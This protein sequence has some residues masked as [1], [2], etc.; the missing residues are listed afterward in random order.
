M[1]FRSR[2]QRTL[3]WN[4]QFFV[5]VVSII[6]NLSSS[7]KYLSLT[8]FSVY[9]WV[10]VI[11]SRIWFLRILFCHTQNLPSSKVCNVFW[12]SPL[13][14]SAHL[15]IGYRIFHSLLNVLSYI[16]NQTNILVIKS[17]FKCHPPMGAICIVSNRWAPFFP[18]IPKHHIFLYYSNFWWHLVR[19]YSRVEI[20]SSGKVK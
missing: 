9:L 5:V 12:F 15:A 17:Q 13:L 2:A 6:F 8:V 16:F 3:S 1:H 20:R 10:S 7:F 14:L 18:E 19:N 11:L 4:F